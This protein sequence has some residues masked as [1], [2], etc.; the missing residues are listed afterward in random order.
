MDKKSLDVCFFVCFSVNAILLSYI[1]A[2]LDLCSFSSMQANSIVFDVC[3]IIVLGWSELWHSVSVC[4]CLHL[5]PRPAVFVNSVLT[6]ATS[7]T[8]GCAAQRSWLNCLV[9]DVEIA[10]PT[11]FCSFGSTAAVTWIWKA[12]F[13]G[14]IRGHVVI[15]TVVYSSLNCLLTYLFNSSSTLCRVPWVAFVFSCSV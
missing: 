1:S 4:K 15:L 2:R 5:E 12:S 11:H 8:R 9:T 3:C 13:V 10:S 7:A 14:G 6:V